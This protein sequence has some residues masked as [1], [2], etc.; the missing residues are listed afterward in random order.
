MVECN[1][2][3]KKAVTRAEVDGV[4]LDVCKECTKYGTE[5]RRVVIKP[6]KNVTSIPELDYSIKPDFSSV[7]RKAREK[8]GL[9][10]DQL[11]T[12]L[13]ERSSIIKRIEEGWEPSLPT[14]RKLERF[15]NLKL[16]E[17]IP[18]TKIKASDKKELTIGDIAEIH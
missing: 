10:Q 15:F 1:L 14:V 8:R 5:L 6:K 18:E 3:N 4:V 9:T 13:V 12:Q 16:V 2:C 17:T 11:A 7:I